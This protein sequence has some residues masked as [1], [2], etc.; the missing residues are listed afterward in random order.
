MGGTPVGSLMDYAGSSAPTGW[1][2]CYGQAI[3]RSTYSALFTAISTVYGIGD[4]STTFNLPDCRGRTAAGKDD[5][6][7]S[8]ANR[9]TNQTGGLNGDT[10]GATGGAETQTLL[11]THLPDITFNDTLDLSTNV[12]NNVTE[13]TQVV[14]SGS[15][16][17]MTVDLNVSIV[18]P[19]V[20]GSV[21]SGGS[22][23]PHNNVQPTIVFNKII[24]TGVA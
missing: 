21:T 2:L 14:Q 22:D 9:L 20:T 6:G 16:A 17:T 7:G 4:G 13:N 23:T 18:N 10:L 11:Q 3:S 24:Y 8:S 1:L 5:M 12:V 15:G 19:T